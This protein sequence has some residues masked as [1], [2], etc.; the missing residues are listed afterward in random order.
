[1]PEQTQATRAGNS[2]FRAGQ[3]A[4]SAQRLGFPFGSG[5]NR[6]NDL[7]QPGSWFYNILPHV[8]Q[9]ALSQLGSDQQP[10][11]WTATQL[12]GMAQVLQTPLPMMNCP[13]RRPAVLLPN[14]YYQS[15]NTEL[16]ATGS[17]NNVR[18]DYAI[19]AGDQPQ[20]QYSD[21]PPDLTTALAWTANR[22]W[23]NLSDPNSVGPANVATGV[24]FSR[25]RVK[26]C[27]VTDGTSCTYMMGEKFVGSDYYFTGT[28]GADNESTYTGYDNDNCRTTYS[29]PLQDVPGYDSGNQFGSAH[30]NG[31]NMA[32]CDGSVRVINYTIAPAIHKNLGNRKDGNVIDGKS[33]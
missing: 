32:M 13:T 1:M 10:N 18:T 25:S 17:Q 12:A 8:E 30:A 22:S 4:V 31:F 3:Q 16:G 2:E 14:I 33:F 21:G 9:L 20:G 24:S 11:T 7:E 6:G 19:C 5:P 29:L 28:S 15:I 27:N 26:I 23:P